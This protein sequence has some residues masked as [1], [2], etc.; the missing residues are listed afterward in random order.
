MILE[1]LYILDLKIGAVPWRFFTED[2]F[3]IECGLIFF[4]IFLSKLRR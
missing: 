1:T 3:Y 4:N 2:Y